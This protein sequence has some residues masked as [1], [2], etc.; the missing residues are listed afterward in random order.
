MKEVILINLCS[1]LHHQFEIFLRIKHGVSLKPM[2]GLELERWAEKE[3]SEKRNQWSYVS[4]QCGLPCDIKLTTK[5]WGY[6]IIVKFTY[7]MVTKVP[8]CLNHSRFNPKNQNEK[9]R[10]LVDWREQI[11]TITIFHLLLGERRRKKSDNTKWWRGCWIN[12]H[13]HICFWKTI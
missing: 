9:I 5:L 12:N 6:R 8:P 2:T 4:G 11:K 10:N 1:F 7:L 13:S 3:I